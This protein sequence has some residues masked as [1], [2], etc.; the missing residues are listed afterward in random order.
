[1]GEIRTAYKIL[2]GE[3]VGKRS[4]GVPRHKWKDNI[5]LYHK[6]IEWKGVNQICVTQNRD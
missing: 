1:M 6:A 4:H 2:I 5:K 3:H